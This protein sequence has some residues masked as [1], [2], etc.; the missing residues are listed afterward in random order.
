MNDLDI[1]ILIVGFSGITIVAISTYKY[2]E[3]VMKDRVNTRP[4]LYMDDERSL[5]MV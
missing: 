3:Y 1:T 5:I 4:A 2:I